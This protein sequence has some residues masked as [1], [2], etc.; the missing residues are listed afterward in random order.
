MKK[1]KGLT[2]IE[3]L[4]V[5]VII[6]LLGAATTPF[7]S[8][9][10]H[11]NNF[12]TTV[13]K[14]I[15]AIRKSQSYAMDNK[16]NQTW[17]ICQTGSNIRI[18]SGTCNTPSYSEDYSIPA[19]V[20]LSGLN[21]TTFSGNR[22]EPSQELSIEIAA[23]NESTTVSLNS[24]GGI[25][26]AHISASPPSPSPTS[27]PAPSPSPPIDTDGDGFEDTLEI[28][29][30]TNPNLACGINA[31]PPDIDD[32]TTVDKVDSDIVKAFNKQ[33][34]PPAPA[35]YDLVP[36]GT[37]DKQDEQVVKSYNNQSCTP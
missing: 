19:M 32:S 18:Y 17:G 20:T 1:F 30:G 34:V 31:W 28:Y 16:N 22:G 8:Q 3:L 7:L 29:I 6:G 12:D 2:V 25:N 26:K 11:L 33:T 4:I 35:R 5:I 23:S 9:F 21:D 36:N 15:S 14:T 24:A 27:T 37:I 13:N 10:L